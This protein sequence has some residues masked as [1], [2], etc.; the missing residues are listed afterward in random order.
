MTEDSL[1]V[2]MKKGSEGSS[3]ETEKSASGAPVSRN[4]GDQIEYPSGLTLISIMIS[5][6]LAGFLVAL[7]SA[8]PLV[9]IP[10]GVHCANL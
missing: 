8:S 4:G 2:E 7:V 5:V 3:T 1:T 9:C 6:Y 10:L